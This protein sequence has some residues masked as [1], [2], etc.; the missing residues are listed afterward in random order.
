M[1]GRYK[2]KKAA[3]YDCA[4]THILLWLQYKPRRVLYAE[5]M[6]FVGNEG[7]ETSQKESG[8]LDLDGKDISITA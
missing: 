1:G 3:Q 4:A 6:S 7:S 5:I 2:V 8:I